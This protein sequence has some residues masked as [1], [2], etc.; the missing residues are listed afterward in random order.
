MQLAAKDVLH[1]V[2]HGLAQIFQLLSQHHALLRI[3][4]TIQLVVLGPEFLV[5]T[6]HIVGQLE[7]KVQNWDAQLSPSLVE[8]ILDALLT[9]EL[10]IVI[11]GLL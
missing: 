6:E 10:K 8:Q 9:H 3:D 7:T 5:R 4:S 11:D 1:G 2:T